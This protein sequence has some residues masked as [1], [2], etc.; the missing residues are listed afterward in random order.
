LTIANGGT[1]TTTWQTGSIP[2]FNGTRLTENNA[3]LFWDNTN[4]RLGVGT[5]TPTAHF[6]V[7]ASGANAT[8]SAEFG[9]SGQTSGTC[10]TFFDTA[11]A[12]VYEYWAAGATNPTYTSTKPAG[13]QN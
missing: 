12:A 3:N 2:F 11:G 9:K 13:C 8:T 5:S 7:T 6:Q 1:G 10:L 4:F